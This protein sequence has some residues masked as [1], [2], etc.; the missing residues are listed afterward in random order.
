[1]QNMNLRTF[2]AHMRKNHGWNFF[3][4]DFK[5]WKGCLDGVLTE[6]YAQRLKPFGD[7]GYGA[8]N[9]NCEMTEEE[10]YKIDLSKF[11]ETD[12]RQLQIK[13]MVGFGALMGFRG[14]NEHTNLMFSQIGHGFFPPNHP[15]Y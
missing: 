2:Y 6:R 14:N 8:R 3:E 13:L 12:L 15:V 1:M 5:N 11:D 4:S 7:E 10:S 9:P